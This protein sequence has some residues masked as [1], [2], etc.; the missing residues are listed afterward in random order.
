[1]DRGSTA[2]AD[3]WKSRIL[4]DSQPRRPGFAS[5]LM[6]TAGAPT[7]M[8]TLLGIN[9]NTSSQPR[10]TTPAITYRA[11]D[12]SVEKPLTHIGTFGPT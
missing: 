3:C 7:L 10:N 8:L 11:A 6:P 5:D 1:M 12:G 2:A 4:L 9:A